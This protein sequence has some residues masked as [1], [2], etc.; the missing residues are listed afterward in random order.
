MQIVKK[1]AMGFVLIALLLVASAMIYIKLHPKKLPPNLIEATGRIDGDLT[2][3][4][5]KYPGRVVHIFVDDGMRVKKG[6]LIA[7]LDDAEMQAQKKALQKQIE[8]KKKELEAKQIELAITKKTLK[9]SLKKAVA[10]VN[11]AKLSVNELQKQLASQKAL[12]EQDRRDL[13]RAEDLYKK[14]LLQKEVLEKAQLKFKVDS[15][16]LEAL[17]AKQKQA[18]EALSIAKSNYE[19]AKVAQRKADALAKGIEALQEGIGALQASKERIEAMMAQMS[20]R[21]PFDGYVVEKVANE[22]EVVGAGMSVATLIAPSS[23]YL[24][25]FV[26]TLQNGKIQ[27]HDKAVIFLDAAPDMPIEAEVSKIAQNAEFTPKEV[28]VRSD[29]IQR[30]FAVYLKPLHPDPLLKLGLPAIGVISIDGKD[31]PDSLDDIPVL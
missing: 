13:T 17:Y 4:N 2:N 28:S 26:D 8:A 20:L 15:H 22:G 14:K 12:V 21:S 19:E 9:E 16:T 30:V 29:R 24:K 11:T 7:K 31:L 25:V 23:L 3:I 1:Y 27:L 6:M 5:A 18:N 10:A